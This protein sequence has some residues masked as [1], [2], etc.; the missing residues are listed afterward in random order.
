MLSS[1]PAKSVFASSAET[2]MIMPTAIMVQM[3]PL[4]NLFFIFFFLP[5]TFFV[6]FARSHF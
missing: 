3:I 5:N 2:G 4:I 1:S 6:I